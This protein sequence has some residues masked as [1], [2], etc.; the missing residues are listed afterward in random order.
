MQEQANRY[1]YILVSCNQWGM[2]EEDVPSI[3]LMLA[4]NISNFR[5]IPDR[6]SQGVLNELLLMKLLKGSLYKHP[7]LTFNNRIVI[8]PNKAFYYGV[9]L[10]GI[11]GQVYM[12]VTTDVQRGWFC[13]RNTII[14]SS[15]TM[16]VSTIQYYTVL[17]SI[18]QY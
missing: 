16:H 8:N 15:L 14:K 17:Y 10:G 4:N 11:I 6:L 12:A 1:G 13:Q 5:I 18:V 7:T 3:V 9:S 2:S